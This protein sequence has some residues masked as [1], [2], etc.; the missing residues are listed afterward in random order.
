MHENNLL[1]WLR[2]RAKT[3]TINLLFCDNI[4][5]YYD[6]KKNCTGTAAEKEKLR[7]IRNDL[8]DWDSYLCSDSCSQICK[9]N[10]ND[11]LEENH[12]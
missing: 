11:D 6:F 1:F 12:K 8:T 9:I 2:T 4:D 3:R 10:L 7:S 5:N